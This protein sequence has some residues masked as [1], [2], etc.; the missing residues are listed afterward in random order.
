MGRSCTLEIIFHVQM[1]PYS[2]WQFPSKTCDVININTVVRICIVFALNFPA[3]NNPPLSGFDLMTMLCGASIK[4][5]SYYRS[6]VKHFCIMRLY[7]TIVG[8]LP[9]NKGSLSFCGTS[10]P[11]NN[12][13]LGG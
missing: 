3:I 4:F 7:I 2:T 6:H 10:R 8:C 1:I 5:G 9:D 11:Y 13:T 12:C